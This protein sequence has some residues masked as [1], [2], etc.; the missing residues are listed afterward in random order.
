MASE[1]FTASGARIAARL[2]TGSQS[3]FQ[4][5]FQSGFQ[6]DLRDGNQKAASPVDNSGPRVARRFTRIRLDGCRCV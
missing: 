1:S 6:S 5:G 3:G 2:A 4:T